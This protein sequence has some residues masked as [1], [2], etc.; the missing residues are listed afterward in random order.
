MRAGGR[1]DRL[2]TAL[3]EYGLTAGTLGST[4][5]QTVMVAL[6]PILLARYTSSATVIGFAIGGEGIVAI[7]VPYWIGAWSD[8]L[9][10]SYAE[11]FGRR[12]FFL[13]L[14]APFMAAAVAIAPFLPGFWYIAGAALVF[15]FTLHGYLAPLWALMVDEVPPDRRGRVQ[16]VRGALHSAG[17]AFGLVAGGLLFSIWEPLPFI[18]AAGI[19]LV[20]TGITFRAAPRTSTPGHEGDTSDV[21][22]VWRRLKGRPAVSW[23][24]LGNALWSSGVDGIRPY[25]FLFATVVLGINVAQTSLLLTVI[26]AGLGIGAVILGHLGDRFGHARLLSIGCGIT[27]VAM[28]LGFYVRTVPGA[29]ALLLFAGLGAATL[30]SLAYPLFASMIGERGVGRDTGLYIVTM[31]FGRIVAPVIIGVAIDVGRSS[32]PAYRGYPYMW[33]IAGGL[34]LLGLLALARSMAH[35]RRRGVGPYRERDLPDRQEAS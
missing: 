13:L 12:T 2:R 6:L 19:I 4:A 28:L 5:G 23:M 31:G 10:Q 15:F 27:G 9:P 7:M 11:R 34:M 26:V 14:T 22:R 8:H 33:P 3:R 24:L 29:V 1:V 30:I 21:L 25:I 32:M 16:G 18:T 20:T 35:A 17:L